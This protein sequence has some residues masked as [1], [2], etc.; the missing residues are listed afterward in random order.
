MNK[1]VWAG[2]IIIHN[3]SEFLYFNFRLADL[4]CLLQFRE[5]VLFFCGKYNSKGRI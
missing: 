4:V 5:Q 1:L 2:Y 3:Q